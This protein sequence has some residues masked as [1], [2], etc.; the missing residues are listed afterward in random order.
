MALKERLDRCDLQV[1]SLYAG[2]CAES[3]ISSIRVR[4]RLQ[5]PREQVGAMSLT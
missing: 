2:L 4:L 5:K 3:N 1:I